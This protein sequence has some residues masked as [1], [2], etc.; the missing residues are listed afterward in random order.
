[1]GGRPTFI[2]CVSKIDP[3]AE[4]SIFILTY[5]T[6]GFNSIHASMSKE[7]VELR[8]FFYSVHDNW[9]KDDLCG[10]RGDGSLQVFWLVTHLELIS[11]TFLMSTR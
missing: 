9:G 5:S 4:R 1:M 10:C 11:V 3:L 8:S 7:N 2:V 6:I